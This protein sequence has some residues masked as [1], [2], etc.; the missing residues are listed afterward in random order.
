MEEN[1]RC[2]ADNG[3]DN[4]LN[5]WRTIKEYEHAGVAGVQLQDQVIS[6]GCG[7]LEG[8]SLIPATAVISKIRAALDARKDE[9]FLI[10]ARTDAGS[11]DGLEAA[12]QRANLYRNAGADM[13]F[14]ESPRSVEELE[15]I[16]R[17]LKD[18]DLLVNM[19]EGGKTPV[20]PFE[21]LRQMGF[22]IVL[23]PTASIRIVAKTLIGFAQQLADKKDT[24]GMED[25]MISYEESN[26]ITGLADFS[27]LEK[28]CYFEMLHGLL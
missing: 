27:E 7:H 18:A 12:I 21:K 16:S 8:K 20:L 22:K 4:A 13:I 5:V 6:K 2:D 10:I 9:D 11:V 26:M 19:V 28:K 17:E 15:I 25:Q 14:L 3:Y 24:L 1:K 23:Y